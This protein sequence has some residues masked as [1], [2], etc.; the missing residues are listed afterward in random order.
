LKK[1]VATPLAEYELG[2]RGVANVM[3]S[4]PKAKPIATPTGTSFIA[5]LNQEMTIDPPASRDD[6]AVRALSE[7]GVV[8]PHPT[9]AESTAAD[10][11][12]GAGDPKGSTAATPTNQAI[13]AGTADAVKIIASATHK[14]ETRAA[15]THF[16]W[17]V[18]GNWVGNYGKLYLPRAIVATGLLGA[19]I[20]R[21]AIYPLDYQDVMG[22]KLTGRRTYKLTF[23]RGKLPPV[24][25]F[26]SLTMYGP[27][28]YLYANRI[29]R[30]EVSSHVG[31]LVLNGNGSLTIYIQH[32]GPRSRIARANWL[33][34]PAGA[35]HLILRLYEPKASAFNGKWKIPPVIARGEHVPT[36]PR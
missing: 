27:D 4:Y 23:P 28:N 2:Q 15:K 12:N 31:K 20:P 11:E 32:A 7:A 25:A 24:R 35:F 1:I 9:N 21:Q 8:L 13:K 33:P 29:N 22:K 18:F 30:Y 16:G 36:S 19:N 3:D 10:Y 5:T 26:W 14:L 6:C 34:A 17:D